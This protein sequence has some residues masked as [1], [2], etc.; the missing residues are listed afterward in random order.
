MVYNF[1]NIIAYFI[2]LFLEWSG[3]VRKAISDAKQGEF[4]ISLYFHNPTKK[5]FEFCIK[6]LK[7]NGFNFIGPEDLVKIMLGTL[8]F[9]K[10]A[11]LITADDGWLNNEINMVGIAEKYH[12]P[13]TIFISTEPAEN[14]VYW[15]TWA[16]YARKNGNNH[17][18]VEEYKKIPNQER[19]DKIKKIKSTLNLPREAMTPNQVSN[20]STSQFLTIG[21][22]THTHPILINC[23]HE[24]V[25]EE[26]QLSTEKLV[27]WTGK[28]IE[29][30][31]YPN[32]DYGDREK[33]ILKSLNY[34]L[35]FSNK[36][37]RLT[38]N[39]LKTP[40]DIPRFGFLEGASDKENICRMVGV[41]QN[42]VNSKNNSP[43]L[44]LLRRFKFE[45]NKRY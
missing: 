35:G 19:V 2:S 9:P 11:V 3:H 23:N 34:K 5:E 20:I 44:S 12:V 17:L 42:F 6:W 4:I 39:V 41:W 7:K 15:W 22:H 16:D 13:L 29:F 43:F 37:E 14:G 40:Y 30:F 36:P 10:G 25:I 31:A 27:K 21:G 38:R 28:T 18:S 1:R 8:P 24:E 32:G 33:N 45:L 26:L